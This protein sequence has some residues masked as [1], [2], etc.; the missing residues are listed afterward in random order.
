MSQTKPQNE[1]LNPLGWRRIGWSFD[2]KSDNPQ[3]KYNPHFIAALLY[4]RGMYKR[5]N[6]VGKSLI[7]QID[8]EQ[9][10]GK[11]SSGGYLLCRTLDPTFEENRKTRVCVSAKQIL[12]AVREI[13]AMKIKGAAIMIDEGGAAAGRMDYHDRI[14]RALDKTVQII[15][16]L[17]PIIVIISPVKQ[18]VATS[19][20][21]MSHKYM[22]FRRG[23]TGHTYLYPYGQH[24][25]S[26]SKQTYTPKPIITIAGNRYILKRI[27]I[28]SI[29]KELDDR[30]REIEES[31]KP[32]LLE[33]LEAEGMAEEIAKIRESGTP[34]DLIPRVLEKW[35]KLLTKK[36]RRSPIK[37]RYLKF[38]AGMISRALHISLRDAEYILPD[39]EALLNTK[40]E[41]EKRK[42]K[43]EELAAQ[44]IGAGDYV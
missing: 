31:L 1:I 7:I 37:G 34:E 20:E 26:I 16:N 24:F 27:K 32:E 38:D 23:S 11:S 25:N 29:P 2:E 19:L 40:E 3:I 30:Y 6:H 44:G 36:D 42:K 28:H 41:I 14:Q 35:D 43:D 15:G 4:Y 12:E 22:H 21:R 9:Q 18:Q 39:C 8:G 33:K 10:T 17:K 5:V 13:R